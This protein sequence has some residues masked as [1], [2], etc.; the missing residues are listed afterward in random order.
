MIVTQ[1][2]LSSLVSKICPGRIEHWSIRE[3]KRDRFSE[4][5]LKAVPGG[6]MRKGRGERGEG[7][8][9]IWTGAISASGNPHLV[10]RPTGPEREKGKEGVDS[11]KSLDG[12][13][14]IAKSLGNPSGQYIGSEL[15]SISV[16]HD[17][18]LNLSRPP[19]TCEPS[20]V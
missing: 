5:F 1:K 4:S 2:S 3:G 10:G 8:T 11:T 16:I 14:K 13:Q 20:A 17:S 15:A 9:A 6:D 19:R 7:S 12:Y 18:S